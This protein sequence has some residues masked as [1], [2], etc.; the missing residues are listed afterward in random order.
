MSW[1]DVM[2]TY[3]TAEEAPSQTEPRERARSL[4][5]PEVTST[6]HAGAFRHV[7][8][9]LEGAGLDPRPLLAAAGASETDLVDPDL[10]VPMA[11]YV[12]LWRIAAP[13]FPKGSLG[14]TFG[15]SFELDHGNLLTYMAAHAA[16][17]G[18]AVLQ[19]D[20][21]R[22]LVHEMLLP[23][24]DLEGGD[25]CLRRVLHPSIGRIGA[26]AES[27]A[28]TW[29]KSLSIYVG[30]AFRPREIWFQHPAPRDLRPYD[31]A[32]GCPVRFE[33]PETRMITDREEL[34]RPLRL[35]NPRL[36]A[37]L[38]EQ[39][40]IQLDSLP[41]ENGLADRVRRLLVEEL[42]GGAPSQDHIARRLALSPRTLQRRLKDEGVVF[43]DLLDEQRRALCDRYLQDR[44]LS[45]QEIA[46]L[47]GYTERSSFYRAFR[48]WT[49]GTP[50]E[51]RK[52]DR[53]E[54]GR[55]L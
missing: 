4:R 54:T 14:L 27:I 8:S 29:V 7:V 23:A 37:Y 39:A 51:L 50:L 47:L 53:D 5:A 16:T 20:R 3:T 17:L 6:V 52:V 10:R 12:A 2:D 42:R 22:H 55:S 9:V 40:R 21:Y 18:E 34:E 11:R 38:E 13:R 19:A 15:A 28:A 30:E 33:M 44:S 24:L 1:T 43:N 41:H 48:R 26:M 25:A 45:I 35:A 32:F 31:E 46:F 49:G 36:R